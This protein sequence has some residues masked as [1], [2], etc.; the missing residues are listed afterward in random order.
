MVYNML[1]KSCSTALLVIS[2]FLLQ[3]CS[4]GTNQLHVNE[5]SIKSNYMMSSTAAL[6]STLFLDRN[7]RNIM[8]CTQPF[9]DAG[10]SENNSLN[11]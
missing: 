7:N 9:P 11:I 5:T 6:S 10:L 3:A 2:I 4:S 1:K 8:I